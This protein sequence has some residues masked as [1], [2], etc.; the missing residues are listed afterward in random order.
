MSHRM[1][2][3]AVVAIPDDAVAERPLPLSWCGRARVTPE[4][5]REF[6]GEHFASGNSRR[7]GLHRGRCPAPVSA[8]FDKKVLRAHVRRR[9]TQVVVAK[10]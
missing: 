8:G 1:W 10:A 7:V 9:R 6:L 2:S 3:S 5:L 4:A